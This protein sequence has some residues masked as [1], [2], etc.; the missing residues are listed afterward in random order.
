MP[1]ISADLNLVNSS[2]FF[3]RENLVIEI[4][5]RFFITTSMYEKIPFFFHIT[6]HSQQYIIR[7]LGRV[8]LCVISAFRRHSQNVSKA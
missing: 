8:R 6:I 1:V 7:F 3:G 2:L 5:H 4:A